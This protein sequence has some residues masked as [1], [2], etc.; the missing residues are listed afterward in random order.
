MYAELALPAVDEAH[1]AKFR[2]VLEKRLV[3]IEQAAKRARVEKVLRKL[4]K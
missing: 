3:K 1:E 4:A 2:Q